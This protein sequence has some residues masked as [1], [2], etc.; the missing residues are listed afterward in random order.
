MTGKQIA[1]TLASLVVAVILTVFGFKVVCNVDSSE[2]VVLQEL[3]GDMEVWSTAGWR[4]Q[5]F[6]K[7]TRYPK[8]QEYTFEHQEDEK[9]VITGTKGC[10][11]IRYN[12]KGSA[13]ISGNL[14]WDMPID[15]KQVLVLHNKYASAQAVENRVVKPAVNRAIYH[16]G[17][18]MSSKE[19]AGQRRG[20]LI[21][22]IKEQATTGVYKTTSREVEE[23]VG[24]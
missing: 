24:A 20:E 21:K 17:P 8:S 4:Y 7:I 19:S 9:G 6:G 16:S 10:L 15:T 14:S 3:D 11:P 12:D 13:V 5:G 22:F 23:D 2:I 18:L 1:I